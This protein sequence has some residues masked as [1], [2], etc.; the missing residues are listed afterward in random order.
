MSKQKLVVIGNGMAGMRCVEYILAEDPSKYDITVFGQEPHGNYNRIML[1]SVLQG[2]ASFKEIIL[3]QRSWYKQ[4]NIKLFAG[5]E[6]VSIDKD[7]KKIISKKGREASYDKLILATGSSPFI[8][9]LPGVEKD[10][11]LSFR[12]IL[13]CQMIIEKAKRHKKAVVIGGGLLGI[14]AAKGLLHQGMI[15][16]VIHISNYLMEKQL[17]PTASHMLKSKLKK[18]GMN[19]L[20]DRET[21]EIIGNKRV[22][23]LRFTDGSEIEADLVVMAAGVKPNVKLAADSGINTNR[24]VI[25]DDFLQTSSP[26]IY[27]IGECAEHNGRVYGLVKPLFEQA[28]ILA[29]HLCQKQTSS[30]KGSILSTQLKVSG[31]DVFSAGDILPS[32]TTPTIQY[33]NDIEAIYKKVYF[34]GDRVIGAVLFGDTRGSTQLLEAITKQKV[35]LDQDKYSLLNTSS[36]T[37]KAASAPL[38]EHICTCNSVTKETIIHAV[39]KKSISTVEEVKK[40][41]RASSSCGGCKPRVAEL[42]D[43]IRSDSYDEETGDRSFCKCTTLTE[44]EVVERIENGEFLSVRVVMDKLGWQNKNGCSICH[45]ALNYYL[46]RKNPLFYSKEEKLPLPHD[47]G[48]MVTPKLEGGVLDT[49]KLRSIVEIA[50]KYPSTQIAVSEE[51]RV[52]LFG[53][54]REDVPGI[55]EDLKMPIER[56]GE[57][58]IFIKADIAPSGCGCK[59]YDALPLVQNL[60]GMLG[61]LKPPHSIKAV[62]STCKHSVHACRKND[63]AAVKVYDCWEVYVGGSFESQAGELFCVIQTEKEAGQVIMA[64]IEYYRST[65]FYQETVQDWLNRLNMIAVREAIFSK[66]SQDQLLSS[67]ERHISIV[68]GPEGVGTLG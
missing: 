11:V 12:T 16:D 41:T 2:D 42:L 62:V 34:D 19:F 53:M 58:Q 51:Q 30:Y 8:L 55:I 7:Q 44:K 15:V 56:K 66:E 37:S 61:V 67:L 17:D 65:A 47:G 21:E 23:G 63:F 57:P 31:I 29:K 14:E 33:R 46:S 50:E 28:A 18:Q 60:E 68:N 25:V 13:D 52:H 48:R 59:K 36:S 39:K 38:S 54:K 20:L 27:A 4:N 6:V 35:F 9:P 64:L 32:S 24:G 49:R 45:P 10:G 40:C 22:K 43:Y 5:E 1:S 26:D 3:H